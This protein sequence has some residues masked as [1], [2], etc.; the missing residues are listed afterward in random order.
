MRAHEEHVDAVALALGQLDGHERAVAAEHVLTC[1]DCRHEFDEVNSIVGEL[2]PAV[3]AVQPKL[4][5]DVEVLQRL[6]I[7]AAPQ[8]RHRSGGSSESPP[9]PSSWSGWRSAGGCSPG[10]PGIPLTP[11]GFSSPMA[12]PSV[13]SPWRTSPVSG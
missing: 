8:R 5:F 6:G 9:L 3:P 2:L 11:R 13:R 1:R 12:R 7:G 10:R 4:G